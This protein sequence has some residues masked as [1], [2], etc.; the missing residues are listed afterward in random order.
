MRNGDNYDVIFP[1]RPNLQYLVIFIPVFISVPVVPS[2]IYYY[3][4]LPSWSNSEQDFNNIKQ[5]LVRYGALSPQ[6][7]EVFSNSNIS[8]SKYYAREA[9]YG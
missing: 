3:S 7:I 1:Y 8:D 2:A 9:R 6:E 4:V 5:V